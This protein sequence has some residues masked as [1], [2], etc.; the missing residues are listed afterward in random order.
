M[1]AAV[2]ELPADHPVHRQLVAYND[3]D[4]DRFVACFAADIRLIDADGSVRAN[5]HHELRRAYTATFQI[6]GLHVDVIGRI[7]A[8]DRIVDHELVH[9]DDLDDR[10]ALVLYQLRDGEIVEMRMLG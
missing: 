9:R 7:V 3:H 4:L 2:I 5:G 1:A 10:E 6:A 8:G